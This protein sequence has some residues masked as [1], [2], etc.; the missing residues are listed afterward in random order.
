MQERLIQAAQNYAIALDKAGLPVNIRV[1]TIGAGA[2]PGGANALA[3]AAPNVNALGA[4]GLVPKTPV[5]EKELFQS[6]LKQIEDLTRQGLRPKP[7]GSGVE[8]IPGGPSDV[9]AEQNRAVVAHTMTDETGKVTLYNKFGEIIPPKSATGET[10]ALKGKPSATFEKTRNQREQLQKDLTVTIAELKDIT[11][12]GGLIDQSTGSGAG[13][14]VDVAAGLIGKATPGAIAAAKLAPIAD[15]AL[16]LVPRFEG[17]QSNQDVIAY[18]QAAGQLADPNLPSKIRK[19]AGKTVL[20]LMENRKGQFVTQTMAAEGTTAAPAGAPATA[21]AGD[22]E[23][24]RA[25]AKA[26]INGGAPAD[27]V[28]QRFKTRTGQDL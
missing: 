6:N 4:G 13:R 9:Y 16:K 12:D 28:R 1:P 21:P 5:Q 8:V 23:S 22:I 18:R 26:A 19:E 15:L 17:P 24:E 10:V 20:R 14:A 3:G 11:K 7:D 2:A 27:A 25:A